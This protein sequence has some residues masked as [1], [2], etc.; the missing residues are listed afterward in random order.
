MPRPNNRTSKSE[1]RVHFKGKQTDR[2]Q[3]VRHG[4]SEFD[5]NTVSGLTEWL[6]ADSIIGYAD[7]NV[8]TT[9][10][11]ARAGVDADPISSGGTDTK[12]TFVSSYANGKPGVSITN[13]GQGQ[14]QIGSA[15]VPA[16]MAT[17]PNTH[18]MVV[19]VESIVGRHWMD[20]ATNR[21]LI[22]CPTDGNMGYYAGTVVNSAT[23]SGTNPIIVCAVFNGASSALYKNGGAAIA[24]GNPGTA[25]ISG[26]WYIFGGA[27]S[28]NMS[29]A[30]ILCYDAALS[31]ADINLV[32]AYLGTRYNITWTTAV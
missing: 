30:E 1:R 8:I 25:G 14:F 27:D 24:N 26:N 5:P 17:Q 10:W 2:R 29:G 3:R 15:S 11:P 31:V 16:G 4:A 18:F 32:G 19:T 22:G 20:A 13:T 9:A 12:P 7:T 23:A 21:E 28:P 6:R